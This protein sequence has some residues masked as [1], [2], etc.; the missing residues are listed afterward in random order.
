M[1]S[2]AEISIGIIAVLTIGL[3]FFAVEKL[4]EE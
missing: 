2:L 4:S 1:E 3:M